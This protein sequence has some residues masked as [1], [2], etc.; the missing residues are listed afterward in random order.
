MTDDTPRFREDIDCTTAEEFL[1]LLSPTGSIFCE[2][3]LNDP[4]SGWIF[5]GVGDAESHTLVPS[6]FRPGADL[7]TEMQSLT[8]QRPLNYVTQAKCESDAVWQFLL[9]ADRHELRLPEDRQ[10][11]RDLLR[12]VRS[13]AVKDVQEWPPTDLLS[14]VGLAQHYGVPTRLLDWTHH[15]YIAAYFAVEKA[16]RLGGPYG[17]EAVAVWAVSLSASP[18]R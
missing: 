13:G 2:E 8:R 10:S 5:R 17:E 16:A 1:G 14:L 6:A 4:L 18:L 9:M 12:S 15:P 7:L 11:T 3:R